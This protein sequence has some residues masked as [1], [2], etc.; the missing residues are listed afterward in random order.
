MFQENCA[1][2]LSQRLASL[3]WVLGLRLLFSGSS[4]QG[5]EDSPSIT[6]QNQMAQ[7]SYQLGD[8]VDLQTFVVENQ[9]EDQLATEWKVLLGFS[10]SSNLPPASVINDGSDG[11]VEMPG[12]FYWDLV[13]AG[14]G[15]LFQVDQ[16]VLY[17]L[18]VTAVLGVRLLSPETGEL[19]CESFSAF[20]IGVQ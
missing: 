7:E 10:S 4:L 13:E 15:E 6:C 5:A 20:N 19:L 3:V 11:S 12:H 9:G 16:Q 1:K 2:T 18:C 8:T 14:L 17:S